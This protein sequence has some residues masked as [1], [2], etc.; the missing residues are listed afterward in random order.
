MI[1]INL[2]LKDACVNEQGLGNWFEQ[3]IQRG[4]EEADTGS[5]ATLIKNII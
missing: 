3:D 5:T 1:Y 4:E 2:L